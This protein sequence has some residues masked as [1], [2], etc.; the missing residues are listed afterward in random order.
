MSRNSLNPFLNT[1][2]KHI[3]PFINSLLLQTSP[4]R[5]RSFDS[6][7]ALYIRPSRLD[8]V[9]IER[10]IWPQQFLHIPKI[11][12]PLLSLVLMKWS[13]VLLH[14]DIRASPL[15]IVCERQELLI[16]NDVAV[17]KPIDTSFL[18]ASLTLP[19][20]CIPVP[21]FLKI[22]SFPYLFVNRFRGFISRIDLSLRC[23]FLCN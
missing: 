17:S 4:H 1:F 21:N 19:V 22:I 11:E 23:L 3:S 15:T 5:I 20:V 6:R 8:S 13:S 16:K 14:N 18:Y 2:L 7:T 10:V 9:E 12:T